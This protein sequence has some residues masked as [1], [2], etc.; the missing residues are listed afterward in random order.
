MKLRLAGT[1]IFL[2]NDD[3][4]LGWTLVAKKQVHRVLVIDRGKITYFKNG[5]KKWTKSL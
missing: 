3:G 4:Y 5:E 1:A 2:G